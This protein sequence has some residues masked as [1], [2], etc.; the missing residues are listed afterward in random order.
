LN[1][2][3]LSTAWSDSALAKLTNVP[4]ELVGEETI[5]RNTFMNAKMGPI[6]HYLGGAFANQTK[7]FLIK[8]PDEVPP[9][10]HHHKTHIA[11]EII[12]RQGVKANHKHIKAS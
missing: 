8:W 11:S 1:Q 9:Q 6:A 7:S 4:P 10:G 2:G 12:E 3:Q 5:L